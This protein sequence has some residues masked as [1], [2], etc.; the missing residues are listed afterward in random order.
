[1]KSPPGMNPLLHLIDRACIGR[2]FSY[3]N[4]EPSSAQFRLRS[5]PGSPVVFDSPQRVFALEQGRYVVRPVDLPLYGLF[6]R[7]DHPFTLEVRAL[8]AGDRVN[9]VEAPLPPEWF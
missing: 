4:Y 5:R 9:G 2:C 6:L 7:Q 3:A 8:R 1:T